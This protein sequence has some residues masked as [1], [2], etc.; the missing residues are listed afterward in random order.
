[1]CF[2]IDH[3]LICKWLLGHVG[4]GCFKILIRQRQH[5]RFSGSAFVTNPSLKLWFLLLPTTSDS[6]L[7]LGCFDYYATW[8]LLDLNLLLYQV[9]FCAGVA[10]SSDQLLLSPRVLGQRPKLR[11]STCQ[12]RPLTPTHRIKTR[13]MAKGRK[14]R[15]ITWHQHTHRGS[16]LTMST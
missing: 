10:R 5:W 3:F 7:H 9:P 13:V 8:L 14:R 1:M 15:F 16:K 4:G 6:Q 2:F 11:G 12:V